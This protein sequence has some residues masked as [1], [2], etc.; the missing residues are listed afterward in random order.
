MGS[1]RFPRSP[2]PQNL[3]PN[4]T[5]IKPSEIPFDAIMGRAS[6]QIPYTSQGETPTA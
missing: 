5:R 4:R 1:Q 3:I 2:V 6:I